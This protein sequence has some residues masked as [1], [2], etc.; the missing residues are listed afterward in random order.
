MSMCVFCR[1]EAN[2]LNGTAFN[3]DVPKLERGEEC[4]LCGKDCYDEV[5]VFGE[6]PYRRKP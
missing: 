5:A 3:E 6:E 1:R 2:D 4:G